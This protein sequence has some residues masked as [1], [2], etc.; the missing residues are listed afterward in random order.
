M[1]HSR[2]RGSPSQ[3]GSCLALTPAPS[4]PQKHQLPVGILRRF[5]FSSSL[6][7]MSVLA[8]LPDEASAHA[9]IKGA[10]EMVASLCR[11]ET[12]TC[13]GTVVCYPSPAGKRPVLLLHPL[14]ASLQLIPTGNCPR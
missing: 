3:R 5:P 9:F 12:G 8:K 7:R 4:P 6:Q 14:S 1:L 2:W 11:K 10:P 13:W